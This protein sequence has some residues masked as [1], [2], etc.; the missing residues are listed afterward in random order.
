MRGI[1][2]PPFLLRQ[3]RL[4]IFCQMLIL[5]NALCHPPLVSG[6]TGDN[7]DHCQCSSRG[8]PLEALLPTGWWRCHLIG[9]PSQG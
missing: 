1:P 7:G 2:S 6:G 5:A 9:H 4:A 8:D 3:T